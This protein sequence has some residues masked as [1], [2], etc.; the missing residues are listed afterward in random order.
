MTVPVKWTREL[1]DRVARR[2]EE[3]KQTRAKELR[4]AI[5]IVIDQINNQ[6]IGS[7]FDGQVE[8]R[9]RTENIDDALEIMRGVQ[10]EFVAAGYIV[11]IQTSS[12][13]TIYVSAPH[14]RPPAP[15]V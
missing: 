9:L 3:R 15:E 14:Q 12:V 13:N 1:E 2:L 6:I 10:Q 8:H 4:K 5:D 7:F 11:N